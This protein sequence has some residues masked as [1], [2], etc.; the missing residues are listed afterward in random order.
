MVSVIILLVDKVVKRTPKS[1]TSFYTGICITKDEPGKL[2]TFRITDNE[3]VL[4]KIMEINEDGF[5]MLT[6]VILSSDQVRTTSLTDVS[7]T[8][9]NCIFFYLIIFRIIFSYYKYVFIIIQRIFMK[10]YIFHN[11][12]YYFI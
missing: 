2:K 7:K 11:K 12:Y 6:N 9:K 1:G 4:P 10:K 3:E 8:F 5:A